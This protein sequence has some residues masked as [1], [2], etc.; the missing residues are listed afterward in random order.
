MSAKEWR[1]FEVDKYGNRFFVCRHPS[2]ESAKFY[3]RRV[4]RDADVTMGCSFVIETD[5]GE[6]LEN[7]A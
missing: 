6:V 4:L 7:S 2:E 1:V 5:T 3:L